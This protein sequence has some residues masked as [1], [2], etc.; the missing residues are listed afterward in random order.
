[1]GEGL[2]NHCQ[3]CHVHYD[4]CDCCFNCGGLNGKCDCRRD[5][6]TKMSPYDCYRCLYIS[7]QII[8]DLFGVFTLQDVDSMVMK[9]Y[10]KES[11]PERLKEK[12]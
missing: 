1:M 6:P 3:Y 12:K 8:G 9:L 11:W 2:I 10:K 4:M 7:P 5:G